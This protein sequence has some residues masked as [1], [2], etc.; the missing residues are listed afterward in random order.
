[1]HAAMTAAAAGFALCAS[2]ALAEEFTVTMSGET[3]A[4]DRIRAATGD[5][6]RFVNDDAANHNVFVPTAGH[7]LDIGAQ[8]P[9]EARTLVLR[10]PGTIQVE[11]VIH[12]HMLLTVEVSG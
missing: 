6:I 3:Y 12:P 8:E 7:A 4:P 11:C 10:T 9:G 2:A 5:T 1:M